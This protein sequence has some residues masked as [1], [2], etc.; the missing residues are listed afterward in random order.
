MDPHSQKIEIAVFAALP[1]VIQNGLNVCSDVW[2]NL[3][4]MSFRMCIKHIV[5]SDKN[6]YLIY[7]VKLFSC[8][9]WIFTDIL[10]CKIFY[11]AK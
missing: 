9:L 11:L 8:L 1:A 6:Y 4:K 7:K 3:K 2:C 10:L 5:K